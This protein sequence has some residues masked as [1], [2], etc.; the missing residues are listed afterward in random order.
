M[1]RLLTGPRHRPRESQEQGVTGFCD[2]EHPPQG[3]WIVPSTA[4][5]PHYVSILS[6]EDQE[7]SD[8]GST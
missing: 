7:L 2:K 8:G 4:K 5:F 3:Q 6:Q 1:P